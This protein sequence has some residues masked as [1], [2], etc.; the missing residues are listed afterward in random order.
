[1]KK[2]DSKRNTKFNVDELI[3][4]LCSVSCADSEYRQALNLAFL[5][6]QESGVIREMKHKWWKEKHGGG[7]CKV[8]QTS[9]PIAFYGGL[10]SHYK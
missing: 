6:L 8:S 4:D 2:K 7:A 3:K 9:N 1:M 10:T 5:N